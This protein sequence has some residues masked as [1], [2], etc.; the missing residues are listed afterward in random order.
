MAR[1][2]KANHLAP[3]VQEA[4]PPSEATNNG[5]SYRMIEEGLATIQIPVTSEA[6]TSKGSEEQS[7]FYNP[8]QQFNRDLSVLVINEFANS[9]LPAKRE[10][11]EKA[12]IKKA[13]K[14]SHKRG[15]GNDEERESVAQEAPTA[16]RAKIED[17]GTEDPQ[18]TGEQQSVPIR[19]TILDALSATGL[20][21]IRYAKELSSVTSVTANDISAAA[22][23]AIQANVERNEVDRIVQVENGNAMAKMYAT[24]YATGH[25]K[26]D[27]VELDPYG[28]AAPFFDAAVQALA[29]GG[30]LCATCTDSAI[31][32]SV[33]YPE[34]TFALYGGVPVKGTFSHEAG[35]R[36]ILHA[37]ATSAARYG[38]AIEPLLSISVDYYA[39]VFVRVWK[40]PAKVKFWAGGTMLVYSCDHGCGAW[41]TQPMLKNKE[42]PS[43]RGPQTH[44][45]GLAQ[46]PT[47]SE[48]CE[49]CGFKTHLSGPMWAGPIHSSSFI[50]RILDRLPQMSSEIYGTKPRIQGV[51]TTA[52]EEDLEYV[53]PD[54]PD[55]N[56]QQ[57][58]A[59]PEASPPAKPSTYAST[60]PAHIDKYP[61]FFIPSA[62]S[63]VI[64][65]YTPP[66]NAFR[67]ALKHLGFRVTRSHA[68]AGTIKTDAPWSVIWEVMRQ[69]AKQK[70]P[71]KEESMREGTAAKRILSRAPLTRGEVYGAH[72]TVDRD[73]TRQAGSEILEFNGEDNESI[74]RGGLTSPGMSH[75]EEGEDGVKHEGPASGEELTLGDD[76]PLE[77]VFDEQLGAVGAGRELRR[78]KGLV[79][80]QANPR[81][82]WGPM[83]RARA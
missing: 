7:V 26:Y 74:K 10:K 28:S 25:A 68:K 15:R 12:R 8:I 61:F 73:E 76:A 41:T 32:A 71:V 56:N 81:P 6:S 72:Q 37:I 51:L 5:T 65:C 13:A 3:P 17:A 79:R 45:H 38:L 34:K 66:E 27:V 22:T 55:V 2:K 42:N 78:T 30:L 59:Q 40:S 53:N 63:G 50:Q 43:S 16:K 54:T 31:F 77:V 14:A 58:E 29:D 18:E 83:T 62:L 11:A 69:W 1:R 21:A 36:I 82:N 4:G 23:E 9:I 80:Y 33:S 48:N 60:D 35:L 70:S 52:L 49:H 39:R 75:G 20:R 44:K 19:F 47:A 57:S 24:A 67:G 64:H 46:G